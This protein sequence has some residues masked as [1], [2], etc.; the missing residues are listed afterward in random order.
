MILTSGQ[1]EPGD[2]QF[3]DGSRMPGSVDVGGPQ[4]AGKHRR[5]SSQYGF[6]TCV[7]AP[8]GRSADACS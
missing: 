2:D 6:D 7:R 8:F 5:N 3:E 4:Q 1:A